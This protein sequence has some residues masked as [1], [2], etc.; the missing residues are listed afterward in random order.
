[1]RDILPELNGKDYIERL[2]ENYDIHF[3]RFDEVEGLVKFIY[4]YWRSDH[5][6]TYSRKI[7]DFQHRDEKNQ[8]YNFVLAVSKNSGEIHSI[9]GFVPTYQYDSEIKNIEIWPCI[10]KSRDDINVKGLG[11]SLYHYMKENIQIETISLLGISEVTLSIYKH[12]NF[13]TGK[14]DQFFL[15]N[16]TKKGFQILGGNTM[17]DVQSLN[18]GS[19]FIEIMQNEFSEIVDKGLKVFINRYKSKNYYINRFFNH[20][21][22]HYKFFS[23]TREQQ[24]QLILVA[25]LCSANDSMCL[26]VVDCI[27]NVENLRNATKAMHEY[28]VNNNIEY[29][30]F[31]EVGI[32]SKTFSDAGFI[33][34]K[35]CEVIVP[36]Y[37]EPF[38]QENIDLDY[39]YKTVSDHEEILFFKADADQDRPNFLEH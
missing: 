39:A 11:V 18:E 31:V 1:M 29:I 8:R 14:T 21:I 23:V 12:W 28:M 13:K 34:R 10:W 33:N 24:P 2:A 5:I 30:D 9:L 35:E 17:F 20:P 25:R 4:D 22:Y 32:E 37:F 16:Y 15:P 7:L 26:R 19:K 6:F 36:N 27:G 3:C 38:L